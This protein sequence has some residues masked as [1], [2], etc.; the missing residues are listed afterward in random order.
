[1]KTPAHVSVSASLRFKRINASC[2]EVVA[3]IKL[4]FL[5]LV[6]KMSD[7]FLG[8]R[9]NIKLCAKLGNFLSKNVTGDETWWF[10]YYPESK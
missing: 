1:V 9:I 7:R 6:G 8:Q 5:R 4:V 10:Q 3:L 2:V